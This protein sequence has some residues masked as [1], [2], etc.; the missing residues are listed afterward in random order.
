MNAIM[1]GVKRTLLQVLLVVAALGCV[2]PSS[3]QQVQCPIAVLPGLT[4]LATL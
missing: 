3:A 1:G 4:A 2:L